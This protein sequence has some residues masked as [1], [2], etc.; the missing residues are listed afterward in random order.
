MAAPRR[1]PARHYRCGRRRLAR[2]FRKSPPAPTGHRREPAQMAPAG[3]HGS[4]VPDE[5]VCAEARV[6]TRFASVHEVHR[7]EDA[8]ATGGHVSP[9]QTCSGVW[10]RARFP[11]AQFPSASISCNVPRVARRP[12]LE[13][14]KLAKEN[15]EPARGWYQGMLGPAFSAKS[16]DSSNS[17]PTCRSASSI[18]CENAIS[19]NAPPTSRS[20]FI[21]RCRR[22]F[23]SKRLVRQ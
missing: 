5:A 17:N 6:L 22:L 10:T 19:G 9:L 4:A 8:Q 21:C 1:L 20:L 16:P 14:R 13:L 12:T 2:L 18:W 3:C 7:R 15:R 23:A 11:W